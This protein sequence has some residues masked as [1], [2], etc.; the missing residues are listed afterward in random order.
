[1]K[2]K[3]VICPECRR[4]HEMVERWFWLF[5]ED[6]REFKK[7]LSKEDVERATKEI[8]EIIN[9]LN[10]LQS[11]MQE[12]ENKICEKMP[13]EYLKLKQLGQ[14]IVF[15]QGRLGFQQGKAKKLI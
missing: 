9:Q 6:Y 14:E 15:L 10:P 5:K 11:E 3:T 13:E 1:M 7:Q 2:L 4:E 12:L 8:P